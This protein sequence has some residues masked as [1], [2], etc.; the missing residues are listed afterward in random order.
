MTF[1]LT[2]R[3]VENRVFASLANGDIVV[4]DREQSK[5]ISNKFCKLFLEKES[6]YFRWSVEHKRSS[7]RNH[8]EHHSSSDPD[9]LRQQR[10]LVRFSEHGENLGHPF[11]LHPS[12]ASH[13]SLHPLG[14]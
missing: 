13:F 6:S 11:A 12:R 1:T 4:Y 9:A 14:N 2:Y 7:V 3:Y 5:L 10:T 8:R